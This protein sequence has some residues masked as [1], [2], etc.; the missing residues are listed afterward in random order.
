MLA[1][2][3]VEG[4]SGGFVS[5]A[6][7]VVGSLT[8]AFAGI[9]ACG[10]IEQE[11]VRTGI[12]HDRFRFAVHGEDHRAFALLQFCLSNSAERR[13]KVVSGCMYCVI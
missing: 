2:K 6:P 8:N 12:L 9:G 4:F 10:D 1:A 5:A 3:F 7:Q 11:L 13:R